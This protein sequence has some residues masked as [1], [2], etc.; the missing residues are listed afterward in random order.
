MHMLKSVYVASTVSE[1]IIGVSVDHYAV[2]SPEKDL[3]SMVSFSSVSFFH[4]YV[5][6][7]LDELNCWRFYLETASK[8]LTD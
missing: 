6:G 3:S 2:C 5:S 8:Q 4:W 1:F 7:V